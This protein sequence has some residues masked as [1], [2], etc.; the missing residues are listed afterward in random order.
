MDRNTIYLTGV[1]I[2]ILIVIIVILRKR[3]NY[4]ANESTKKKKD[5]HKKKSKNISNCPDNDTKEIMI[6]DKIKEMDNM[7]SKGDTWNLSKEIEKFREKQD[8]YIES[9]HVKVL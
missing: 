9:I 3:S 8:R 5:K 6:T 1:F 4:P 7:S 2:V